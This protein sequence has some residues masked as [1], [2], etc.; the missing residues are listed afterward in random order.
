MDFGINVHWTVQITDTIRWLITDTVVS[1]W[2][3]AGL[4]LTF[5]VTVRIK[6]RKWSATGRPGG[7][8]S[9]VEL[10]VDTF[11]NLYKG[12][13]G[14]RTASLIPWFFA[15]F[16]FLIL[17]NLIGLIGLRPPTADWGM[18]FALAFSSFVLM[19]FAGL[20][21]RAKAY[22]KSIF[23]DPFPV[24]APINIVGELAKPVSMS[25]RLFGNVLGGYILLSLIYGMAPWLVG[26]PLILHGYFDIFAGLLQAFIFVMLS[27][28]FVGMN[29]ND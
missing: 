11:T 15:L 7:L 12:N 20:R 27:M 3:V 6:S 23:W 25:F 28:C 13:A 16:A 1:T 18:T 14:E 5:A 4:L 26:L 19:V 2:V 24:F 29:A 21:Y 17:S 8:Q 10:A 22:L 9:A